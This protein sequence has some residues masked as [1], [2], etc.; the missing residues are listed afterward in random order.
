MEET[1]R[2]YCAQFKG[3]GGRHWVMHPPP[4]FPPSQVDAQ[5]HS[6]LTCIHRLLHI[7]V[8]FLSTTGILRWLRM[9]WFPA[10]MLVEKKNPFQNQWHYCE[11]VGAG[12]HATFMQL[13]CS[14]GSAL[15]RPSFFLPMQQ[16]MKSLLTPN[17][18]DYCGLGLR[19]YIGS[20]RPF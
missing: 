3:W 6:S 1:G 16:Q 20:L 14:K 7:L 9:H 19:K 4:F 13:T 15:V 12:S 2:S 8:F 10:F 5:T 17:E 11:S 18:F